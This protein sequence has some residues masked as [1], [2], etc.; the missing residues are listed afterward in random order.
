MLYFFTYIGPH[1][2]VIIFS[3]YLVCVLLIYCIPNNTCLYLAMCPLFVYSCLRDITYGIDL[4]MHYV[5]ST[6]L[7]I[8]LS[9]YHLFVYSCPRKK[10][11]VQYCHDLVNILCECNLTRHGRVSLFTRT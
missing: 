6:C 8:Y 10:L 3:M 2:W 5:C 4:D 11:T 7:T 1:F 9:M